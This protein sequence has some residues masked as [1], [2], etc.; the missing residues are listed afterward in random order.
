MKKKHKLYLKRILSILIYMGAMFLLVSC[1]GQTQTEEYDLV[2]IGNQTSPVAFIQK[3][4]SDLLFGWFG[5]LIIS[6]IFG[7]LFMAFLQKGNPVGSSLAATSFICWGLSVFLLALGL[8]P[9]VIVF[10]LL[11]LTAV[12]VA[13]M[14]K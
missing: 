11:I 8:V 5:T 10:T 7:V 2:S 13:F 12:S 6:I 9:N 3:V 14:E 4:N 1:K